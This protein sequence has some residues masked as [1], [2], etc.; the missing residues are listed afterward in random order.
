M[1]G[2]FQKYKLFFATLAVLFACV[3]TDSNSV[4]VSSI[5]N[6]ANF[7]GKIISEFISHS[8]SLDDIDNAAQKE[9]G[10]E[11]NFALKD[12]KYISFE[13][14][15]GNN[16][17]KSVFYHCNIAHHCL[18]EQYKRNSIRQHKS[19]HQIGVLLI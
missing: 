19:L 9:H 8:N 17:D 4:G 7:G 15:F 3:V 12:N 10:G 11:T 18:S 13:N 5:R 1:S 16:V 6:K 2:I 14:S